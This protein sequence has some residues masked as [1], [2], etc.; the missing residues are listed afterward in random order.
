MTTEQ[1]LKALAEL[2][3]VTCKPNEVWGFALYA[4][5][6]LSI[7]TAWSTEQ[8]A[9]DEFC[10]ERAKYLTSYDAILPLIQKQPVEVKKVVSYEIFIKARIEWPYDATPEQ[11]ADALLRAIGKW[12]E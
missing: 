8:Y 12:E 9:W 10:K 3:G 6:G 1:K 7:G 11:L 2:D 5:S 4:P